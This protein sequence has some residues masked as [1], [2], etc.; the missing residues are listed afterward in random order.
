MSTSFLLLNACGMRHFGT[1]RCKF[2]P[3]LCYLLVAWLW[4]TSFGSLCLMFL[5]C[6]LR[7]IILASEFL[8]FPGCTSDEESA[9]NARDPGLIPRLGRSPEIRNG[10]PLQYSCLENLM[11]RGAWR[12][13]VLRVTKSRTWLKQLSTHACKGFYDKNKMS[14]WHA[15]GAQ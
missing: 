7:I 2:K 12:A 1:Y 6:K 5:N 13:K 4:E 8:G 3:K 11:D 10:N 14:A 9:C 15:L